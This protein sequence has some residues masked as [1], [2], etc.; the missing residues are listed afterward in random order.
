V[1]STPKQIAQRVALAL[2][3]GA[4]LGSLIAMELAPSAIMLMVNPAIAPISAQS[5]CPCIDAATKVDNALHTA[6]QW[7]LSGMVAGA[8]AALVASELGLRAL[9]RWQA[10]KQAAK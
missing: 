1:K 5:M 7:Q 4:A 3:L 6:L 2:A 8:L 10:K 9:V